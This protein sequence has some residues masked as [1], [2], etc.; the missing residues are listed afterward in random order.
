MFTALYIATQNNHLEVV[1][2]LVERGADINLPANSIFHFL[3]F[4][5]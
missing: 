4:L 3:Y 2:V 5:W 1:K